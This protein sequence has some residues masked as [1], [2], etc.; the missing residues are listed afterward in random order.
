MQEIGLIGFGN[1]GKFLCK[2]LKEHFDITV[3][4]VIDISKSTKELSVKAGSLEEVASKEIVIIAVPVQYFESTIEGIK[5]FVKPSA[6][7]LDVSSVKI[8]PIK[9]MKKL[10]PKNVNILGTH[11]LF[12]PQSGKDGIKGLKIVLCPVRL[13]NID[14]IKEFLISKFGLEV[15][16]RTPEE[17]DKEMAYVQGLTHF[18]GKAINGMDVKEYTQKTVAYGHLFEIKELLKTGSMELFLTIENENPFAL[19]VRKEFVKKLKEIENQ[20]KKKN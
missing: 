20:I 6:L 16:I 17:H 2:H 5:G 14:K 13:K 4:D 18:I 7:I 9:I 19:K 1:F 3:S 11:P 12:G 8:K 10:L 15:L